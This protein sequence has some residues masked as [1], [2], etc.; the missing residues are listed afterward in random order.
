[1]AKKKWFS[2]SDFVS[3]LLIAVGALMASFS[4][5]CILIPNDAIDYGTAGIAIVI[6]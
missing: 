3:Y 1:M 5:V 6:Y 2:W 4:V